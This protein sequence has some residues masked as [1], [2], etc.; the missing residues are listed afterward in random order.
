MLQVF[1]QFPEALKLVE[2]SLRIQVPPLE[3]VLMAFPSSGGTKGR[4]S[5]A[6]TVC[7]LRQFHANEDVRVCLL[8]LRTGAAGLNLT[9]GTGP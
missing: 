9:R 4:S 3:H 2:Q 8:P 7:A 5:T 6:T 1:S